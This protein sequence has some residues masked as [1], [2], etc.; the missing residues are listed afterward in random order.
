MRGLHKTKRISWASDVNL[1]Q[2][3]ISPRLEPLP[4]WEGHI[5]RITSTLS[6]GA[7]KAIKAKGLLGSWVKLFLLEESPSQVGLSAQDHLQVKASWLSHSSGTG[8]D[9]TLPPGFEGAHPANQPQID[10]SQIPLIKWRCPPKVVL[11]F[12]WQVVSGDESK[13]MEI[14]N[15]REIRVLE[16]VYPRLSAI[17][18]NPSVLADVEDSS[19]TGGQP[20]I[21]PITPI[22]DEDAGGEAS[23]ESVEPFNN[24]TSSQSFLSVQGISAPSQNSIP[25][26]GNHIPATLGMPIAAE[27]DV[28]AAALGAIVNNNEHGNMIDHELLIKILSNPKM[29]EKLVTDQQPIT[30]PPQMGVSDSSHM[31][32]TEINTPSSSGHFYPP[33]HVAGMGHFPDARL[34]PPAS[35]S[36]HSSPSVGPPPLAKDINYYKSLIQQ[37]GGDRQDN[38]PPFGN[39]HSDHSSVNQESN[40]NYKPRDSKPKNMKP[41]IYFNSARGCNKG[42]NCTF[43]HDASFQPRGSSVPEV[44]KTKRMKMDREISS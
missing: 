29:I 35:I 42:A 22:E 26:N 6:A 12:T 37:H 3:R 8:S 5:I 41:C 33:P 2:R 14:Q 17:P 20:L 30:R 19:H 11:N 7:C 27:P 9:D 1:C 15:Q 40:N 4:T 18:L 13:E 21:I 32:R 36:V 44:H 28:V 16:A 39:R 34:P 24:S 25:D 38:F 10:L 23:S 43:Q 31:I